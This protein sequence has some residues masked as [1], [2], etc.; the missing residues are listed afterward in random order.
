MYVNVWSCFIP[1]L[2]SIVLPTA[3]KKD[4]WQKLV[5][6]KLVE[7]QQ[8]LSGSLVV[9]APYRSGTPDGALER[10]VASMAC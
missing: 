3:Q 6:A 9:T 10:S 1:R 7:R 8:Q 4:E 5:A 2:D